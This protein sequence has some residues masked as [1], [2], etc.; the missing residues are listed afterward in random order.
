MPSAQT[1]N[2]SLDV[3]R[4]IAVLLV[5]GFHFPR[6]FLLARAGW[7]GVDLFFVL[8]GFLISGLL[9]QEYKATGR[10]S[11]RRFFIRR[12]LK[13]WPPFY[14]FIAATAAI[15]LYS[16]SPVPWRAFLVSSLFLQNYLHDSPIIAGGVFVHLWSLAVEE[17]FY[18]LLPLLFIVL[19]KCNPGPDPFRSLPAIF[20][21]IAGGC[22]LL[23]FIALRQA[24]LPWATYRSTIT[25]FILCEWL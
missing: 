19:L 22:L 11:F 16:R 17:H 5:L 14:T 1:R 20:G 6:Y 8:S 25:R 2:Q 3:L 24:A 7:I 10:I 12:G 13:I 9:F 4:C 18:V 23:R 15:F 21:S